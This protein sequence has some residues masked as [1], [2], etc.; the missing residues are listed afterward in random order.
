MGLRIDTRQVSKA[1]KKLA[2]MP[3]EVMSDAYPFLKG[4]TPRDKGNARNKTRYRSRDLSIRSEYGYAG[5]L[6]EGWSKQAPRGFTEPTIKEI[7]KLID[8]YIRDL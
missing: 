4:K 6:D 8:Q 1:M 7:D 5:R 2:K 3:N